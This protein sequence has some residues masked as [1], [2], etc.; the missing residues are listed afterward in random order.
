MTGPKEMHRLVSILERLNSPFDGE[1]AAAGLLA[2]RAVKALG[3]TWAE[4][5][6]PRLGG[7]SPGEPQHWREQ[8]QRCVLESQALTP[9]EQEFVAVLARQQRVSRRQK[10][11]LA[12]IVAD[13]LERNG[14]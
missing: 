13:R 4:I 7:P 12:G 10:E 11:V 8:V 9:W 3:L 1:R 6:A 5:V 2:S 14:R